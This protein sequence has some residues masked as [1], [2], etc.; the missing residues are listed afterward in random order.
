MTSRLVT[1]PGSGAED[2]AAAADF[3]EVVADDE[4]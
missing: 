2:R 4:D 3:D 1:V